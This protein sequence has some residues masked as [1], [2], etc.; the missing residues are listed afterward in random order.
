MPAP[1]GSASIYQGRV[2]TKARRSSPATTEYQL[3]NSGYISLMTL[4]MQI[5]RDMYINNQNNISKNIELLTTSATYQ[6]PVSGNSQLA[7]AALS[8]ANAFFTEYD[9]Y[10]S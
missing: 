4:S 10:V 9:S 1:S 5:Y 2:A 8:A 7:K 3:A 6:L